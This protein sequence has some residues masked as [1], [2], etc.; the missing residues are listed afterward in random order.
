MD[1][2][3]SILPPELHVEIPSGFNTAGHVGKKLSLNLLRSTPTGADQGQ[4]I[5]T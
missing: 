4:P 5:L 1:V 3:K 2:M